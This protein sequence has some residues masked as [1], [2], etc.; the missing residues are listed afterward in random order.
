MSPFTCHQRFVSKSIFTSLFPDGCVDWGGAFWS[1][2]GH[3]GQ[4][5]PRPRTRRP[6]MTASAGPAE[7][8]MGG[9]HSHDT[10]TVG[11]GD[12]AWRC[13]CRWRRPSGAS[14]STMRGARAGLPDDGECDTRTSP[15]I[16]VESISCR[17]RARP[18]EKICQGKQKV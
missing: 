3:P 14:T 18:P 1:R 13:Y 15:R 9:H 10:A 12:R 4:A 7:V 11:D 17:K 5:K 6:S 2:V 16:A 8:G